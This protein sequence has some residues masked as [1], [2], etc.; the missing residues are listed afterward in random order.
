MKRL[1]AAF[2]VGT[3]LLACGGGASNSSTPTSPS[4]PAADTST[5]QGTVAGSAGQSGTLTVTVQARVAASSASVFRPPFVATLYAQATTVAATASLHI[6]RG[7]TTAL[8]GTFDSVTKALNL[9]GGGFTFKGGVISGTYTGPSGVTGGFSTLSTANGT[10]TAYCGTF[11]NG[12][13]TGVFNIQVSAIGSV[14]GVASQGDQVAYISGQVTGTTIKITHT[15]GGSDTGTIQN[16]TV[17]GTADPGSGGSSHPFSGST[18][19]CR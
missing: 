4:T 2:V 11:S 7:S 16:G 9:S 12:A 6:A 1:L 13:G 14:S 10:V 8:T 19:A 5:F 18:S 3:V 17:S 15:D